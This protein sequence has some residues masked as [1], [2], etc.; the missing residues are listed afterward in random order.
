MRNLTQAQLK[1]RGAILEW[2]LAVAGDEADGRRTTNAIRAYV[3]RRTS[4]YVTVDTIAK[5]L[6]ALAKDGAVERSF[7]GEALW[8]AGSGGAR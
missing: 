3:G 2:L 4:I 5:D 8:R 6:H 7:L 1:R